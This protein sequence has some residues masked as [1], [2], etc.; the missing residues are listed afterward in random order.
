MNGKEKQ[1]KS[2][3]SQNECKRETKQLR[4]LHVIGEKGKRVKA[5]HTYVR[6]KKKVRISQRLMSG[7]KRES[8]NKSE[9]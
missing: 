3:L 7:W 2:D 8:H 9:G 1:N 4:Y 5:S 6:M